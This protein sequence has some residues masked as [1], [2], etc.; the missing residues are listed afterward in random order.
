M[1]DFHLR[2]TD[3]KPDIQNEIRAFHKDNKMK[4]QSTFPIVINSEG[5]IF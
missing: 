3:L 4:L 2:F 5:G 1:N